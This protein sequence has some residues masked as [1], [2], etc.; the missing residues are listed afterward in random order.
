MVQAVVELNAKLTL[1]IKAF[2]AKVERPRPM[3]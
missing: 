1:Q 2:K 3:R